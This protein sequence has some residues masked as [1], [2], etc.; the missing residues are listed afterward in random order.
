M[1]VLPVFAMPEGKISKAEEMNQRTIGE[2]GIFYPEWFWQQGY[3]FADILVLVKKG[4]TEQVAKQAF[5]KYKNVLVSSW[6]INSFANLVLQV[7]YKDSNELREILEGIMAI[8][9]VDRVEF[10]EVVA[11]V[12]RRSYEQVEHNMAIEMGA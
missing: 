3:R 5:S 2:A 10:S 9:N 11:I 8:D 4:K 6:R 1:L 12:D 7:Y